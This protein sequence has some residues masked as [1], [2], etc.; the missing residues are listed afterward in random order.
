MNWKAVSFDWNQVRAFLATV[1]EG[2]LSAAARA[3]D[4]CHI[5]D[6]MPELQC[7]LTDKSYSI[8]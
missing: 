8:E 7:W 3:L 1:E 2:S 4:L 5:A 6:L